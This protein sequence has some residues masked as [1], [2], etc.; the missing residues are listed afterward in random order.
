VHVQ[1]YCLVMP[2]FESQASLPQYFLI[3]VRALKASLLSRHTRTPRKPPLTLAAS[4]HAPWLRA[5]TSKL[6]A[7]RRAAAV[8]GEGLGRV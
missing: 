1:D 7:G 5:A 2:T 4:P 6:R 8:R 3:K